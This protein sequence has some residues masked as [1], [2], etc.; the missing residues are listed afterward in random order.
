MNFIAWGY[1]ETDGETEYAS[2]YYFTD[3][4]E[5]EAFIATLGLDFTEVVATGGQCGCLESG[6]TCEPFGGTAYCHQCI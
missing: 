1:T 3:K 4:A 2:E 6:D 5:A